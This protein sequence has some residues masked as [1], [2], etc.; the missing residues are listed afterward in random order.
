MRVMLPV[1]DNGKPDFQF[2]EDFVRE[3]MTKKRKQYRNFV[4]KR[5]KSLELDGANRGGTTI[6]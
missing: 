1:S 2:M 5:L 4:E 3:L 6:G